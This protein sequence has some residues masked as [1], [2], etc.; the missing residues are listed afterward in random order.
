[1]HCESRALIDIRGKKQ[2]FDQLSYGVD[3]NQ[4]RNLACYAI[5]PC[6]LSIAHVCECV[7]NVTLPCG[8]SGV[9]WA[10]SMYID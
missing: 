9:Y 5:C 4:S 1:M 7:R 2:S 10:E 8:F 3:L 6:D